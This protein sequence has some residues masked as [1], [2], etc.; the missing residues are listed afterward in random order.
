MKD[1]R[2][3][4]MTPVEHD[5][6]RYQVFIFKK[7][8]SNSTSPCEVCA[9]LMLK[10]DGSWHIYVIAVE[11]IKSLSSTAFQFY[12][13]MISWIVFMVLLFSL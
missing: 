3:Y 9:L 10:K 2:D 6:L 13:Y 11:L 8:Y 4:R 7:V 5:E 12:V 1:L